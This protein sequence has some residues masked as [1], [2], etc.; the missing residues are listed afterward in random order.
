LVIAMWSG[1]NRI[2]WITDSKN[3]NFA[4]EY[5]F[6]YQYDDYNELVVGGAWWNAK[7]PT[8][9]IKTLIEYSKYQ[10]TYS[11]T[12][13]SWLSM[14]NLSNYLKVNKYI[15]CYTSFLKYKKH[16]FP[17][18]HFADFDAE[19]AKLN[20]SLDKEQW[21]PLSDDDH[22]GDWARKHKYL[23]DDYFHPKFPEATEGWLKEIL[24]PEL[25]KKNILYE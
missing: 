12:L 22:Y 3:S 8:P 25:I 5:S 13:H 23:E 20:L 10:S 18:P 2:D 17:S 9:L 16:S 24:I 14:Q 6:K 15:Y 21:L 19:L 1:I 4:N 11:L 7:N